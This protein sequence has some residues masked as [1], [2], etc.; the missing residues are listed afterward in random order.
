MKK[1]GELIAPLVPPLVTSLVV[2]LVAA[3]ALAGSALAEPTRPIPVVVFDMSFV[4]LSQEV[5]YGADNAPE[6]ARIRMLSDYFRELVAA[7]DRYAVVGGGP[8]EAELER[9]GEVFACNGCEAP[10]ARAAGAERSLT[11]SVRKVSVLIQSVII[12]ERDA[13]TGEVLAL[14]NVSIRNNTDAAWRRGLKWLVT[15][16]LLAKTQ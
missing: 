2:S 10:L 7:S 5:D 3:A 6:R 13:K 1:P 9:Y 16:R 8:S 4:N 12:R 11:G 14:Y 15:N